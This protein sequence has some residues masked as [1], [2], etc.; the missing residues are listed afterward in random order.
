MLY[1]VQTA[2]TSSIPLSQNI[3]LLFLVKSQLFLEIGSPGTDRETQR[4]YGDD[5][6]TGLAIF[7]WGI[8]WRFCFGENAVE[9]YVICLIIKN[10][11]PRMEWFKHATNSSSLNLMIV[12]LGVGDCSRGRQRI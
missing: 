7:F 6:I 10:P 5:E 4:G 1:T 11:K 2:L 3:P 9:M 12:F 8:F